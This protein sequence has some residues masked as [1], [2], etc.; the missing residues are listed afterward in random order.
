RNV[1]AG[2]RATLDG[3]LELESGSG[4]QRGNAQLD[5]AVLTTAAG[6]SHELAL[7][8]DL[9]SDRL[10]VSDLRLADVCIDFELTEEAIDD[11]LEVKLT[12]SGD[13]RLAG[14]LIDLDAER[15]I[16][17][18]ELLQTDPESLLFRDRKS[19]RLNSSH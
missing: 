15:W 3:I 9:A 4:R 11:D 14:L 7:T 10:L 17:G 1:L 12:H 19:T 13:Q 2:N 18:R 16:L 8:L 6:L 5:V